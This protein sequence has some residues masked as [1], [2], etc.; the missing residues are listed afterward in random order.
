MKLFFMT[1]AAVI[2]VSCASVPKNDTKDIPAVRD[3]DVNRYL[4]KWYE[5]ARLP[6]WFEKDL[7]NV[8]ATYE[9]NKDGTIKVINAGY[10]KTSEGKHKVAVGK[11]WIPDPGEAARLRVRFFWPFSADYKIIRLDNENYSYSLVTSSTKKY[12]WILSRTPELSESIYSELV[13]FAAKKGYEAERL[14]KV[15]QTWK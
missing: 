8:T 6:H 14:I 1:A 11:A 5:I 7:V 13:D 3:F 9:L 10:K 4:G 2:F 15:Q 12:L